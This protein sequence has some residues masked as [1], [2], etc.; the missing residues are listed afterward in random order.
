MINTLKSLAIA[1]RDVYADLWQQP[2]AKGLSTTS[3]AGEWYQR[4]GYYRIANMAYGFNEK[5]ALQLTAIY[6]GT[7]IIAEDVASLPLFL[8][9]TLSDDKFEVYRKHPLHKVLHDAPNPDT[10]AME[11]R[12]ALTTHAVLTGNGYA[13]IARRSSDKT[14]IG[15]WQL[16]P[17]DVRVDKTMDG[18]LV[19]IVKEGNQEKTYK[20]EDIFHLRGWTSDGVS[21]INML[22]YAS[23]VLGLTLAQ[24]EYAAKFF[25]NDHTPGIILKHPKVLGPEGVEGVKRAWKK[26]VESHDVAVTQEGME[27]EQIGSTNT[28]AQLIEQ[29][30]FQI[31]EVCRLLR[32]TPHKLAELSRATFSNVTDLNRSHYTETMRPWLVRWEQTIKRCCLSNEDAL[33]AEHSIEGYLRGDFKTQ[34]EGFSRLLEKGVYSINEVRGYLNL[35]PVEGGDSHHV[36]MQMRDVAEAVAPLVESEETEQPQ[37]SPKMF[38]VKSIAGR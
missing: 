4:N 22:Q 11:F 15:L 34:T 6:G 10:T 26:A 28:E 7:K 2:E 37:N 12:E 27:V 38:R 24:N 3:T 20:P 32:L 25:E 8:Y 9:R 19:Y 29:R 16:Q 13:K 1:H 18:R 5:R 30:T 23:G 35:N 21:G 36:Q 14:V 33:Y 17:Q 31:A